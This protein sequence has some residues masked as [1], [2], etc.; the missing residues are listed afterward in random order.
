MRSDADD[1]SRNRRQR[2]LQ[3]YFDKLA[4]WASDFEVDL[5]D[6]AAPERYRVLQ[7]FF[8]GFAPDENDVAEEF[9]NG[10]PGFGENQRVVVRVQDL[11]DTESD[12][13]KAK[14]AALYGLEFEAGDGRSWTVHKRWSELKKL[15]A[16][17]VDGSQRLPQN[18]R[19]KAAIPSTWLSSDKNRSGEYDANVLKKRQTQLVAYWNKWAAWAT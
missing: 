16:D 9:D 17:L 12:D 18:A 15:D 2:Q 5:F 4:R 6:P 14:G 7:D 8:D 10:G 1:A 13:A 11:V 3:E 19:W